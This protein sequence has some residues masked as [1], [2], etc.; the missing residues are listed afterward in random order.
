MR[1]LISYTWYYWFMCMHWLKYVRLDRKDRL[2]NMCAM[3]LE[4][5]MLPDVSR[6]YSAISSVNLCVTGPP[7]SL[8]SASVTLVGCTWLWLVNKTLM[9]RPLNWRCQLYQLLRYSI[10]RRYIGVTYSYFYQTNTA[11]YPVKSENSPTTADD[12]WLLCKQ[13]VDWLL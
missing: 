2:K 12:R 4:V 10:P 7:L 1:A 6:T 11:L 5:A 13:K 8:T 3:T 9:A